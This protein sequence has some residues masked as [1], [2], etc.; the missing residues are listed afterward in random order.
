MPP[1]IQPKTKLSLAIY[2]RSRELDLSVKEVA[3]KVEVVYETMRKVVSGDRPPSKRLL[4]DICRVLKLDF[5]SL[6]A[7]LVGQKLKKYGD[8]PA[9]LAGKNPELAKIEEVW[10]FLTPEQKDHVNWL[11]ESLAQQNASSRKSPR[12]LRSKPV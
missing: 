7:L 1:Q 12:H 11:V 4:R 5:D 6:N 2:G 9:Q 3:D 10:D 8:V